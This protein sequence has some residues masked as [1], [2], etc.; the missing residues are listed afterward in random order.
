[1]GIWYEFSLGGTNKDRFGFDFANRSVVL[2]DDVKAPIDVTIWHGTKVHEHARK[3][4]A[5]AREKVPKGGFYHISR[6]TMPPNLKVAVIGI[7][8]IGPRHANTV[9]ENPD[10]DLVAIVDPVPS[11]A[12]FAAKLNT[13]HYKTVSDLLNSADKPD[14][15]IICTPN[16][17]HAPISKELVSAGV[18][19][20]IEKPISNDVKSGEDLIKHIAGTDVKVLVGHHRRFNPYMIAAKEVVSSGQLGSIVAINGLWALYKPNDYYDPPTDWR[21]G[22]SGGVILINMIHEV[23]L[24]HYLFGPITTVHAE[25]V[26]SQRGFEAEE[27]AALTLRFKSGIVGSFVVADNVPSPYNFE[28]GTGE[29]PLIPK[30]G[31]DFYRVFGTEGSLSIPDMS[32]WSYN[33]TQKTW[34]SPLTKKTKS[35]EPGVPFELQLKHFVKVIRGEE[36][37]SCSAKAGLGA[38]YVCQAIKDAIENNSTVNIEPYEL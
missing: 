11:S 32:I 21:R 6:E 14:A 29:N 24:L 2:C 31:Q 36:E 16:Y 25:K 35:V 5:A 18:H 19:A 17:T 13:A 30:A 23:D 28:S 38:L 15:A 33:G 27:G 37:V 10:T 9:V 22:K 7:G 3:R 26:A 20:L 12:E 34:H 4:W 1:M 8:L